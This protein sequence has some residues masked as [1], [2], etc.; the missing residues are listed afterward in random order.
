[1]RIHE[2]FAKLKSGNEAALIGYLTAGFPTMEGFLSNLEEAAGSGADII[3][4]GI[5]FSDPIAD[6]PT[7]QM[8]SQIG[9]AN[10]AT[11]PAILK[12]I[13][14][15]D[16]NIPLVFMSY[17]NPLLAYGQDRLLADMIHAKV[18]GLI[19]PDL[20]VE[21]A[22]S[23]KSAA[24]SRG[25]DTIFLVTPASP[26]ERVRRIAEAS[27]GFVYCVSLTGT[28]GAR[29]DLSDDLPAF[30]DRVRS[31]TNT[32]IAVGFGISGPEHIRRLLPHADGM[33]VGSRVIDAIRNGEDVGGLIRKLKDATRK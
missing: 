6:G 3:E 8:S 9:L 14:D 7:I 10:G 26:E 16:L 17:L 20:P 22:A 13:R 18:T 15:L 24:E 2:Q 29:H 25:V 23:W 28:T 30:L 32:P 11:L 31:F 19:V 4:I 5:P 33:I 1:M 27:T 21:E 12:A